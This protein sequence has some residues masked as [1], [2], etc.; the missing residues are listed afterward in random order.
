MP[1]NYETYAVPLTDYSE[2]GCGLVWDVGI[3]LRGIIQRK[4]HIYVYMAV[5]IW[6]NFRYRNK[7]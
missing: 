6:I 7:P 4:W 1:A 2:A 5:L 3:A